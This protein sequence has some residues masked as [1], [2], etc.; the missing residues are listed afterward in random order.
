M[1]SLKRP[2][3]WFTLGPAT[4]GNVDA[5]IAAGATGVRYTLSYS[6]LDYHIEQAQRV[7]A[8]ARNR[9]VEV[10]AVADL[11]GNKFRLGAVPAHTYVQS[12]EKLTLFAGSLDGDPCR[13]GLP[14]RD[15][16]FFV[17]LEVGEVVVIGDGGIDLEIES[18]R[19][20]QCTVRVTN[21]GRIEPNRGLTVVGKVAR[22]AGLTDRDREFVK[23]ISLTDC[24]DVVAVSFVD[25]PIVLKEVRELLGDSEAAVLAKIETESGVNNALE[26]CRASDLIMAAR[27]DLALAI[28]WPRLYSAV[29]HIADCA[30]ETGTPWIL[31]TQLLEGF[32]EFG[33]PTRAEMCDLV[34]W[35]QAG[36]AGVMLSKET[37]FG[38]RA[39]E[40]IALSLELLRAPTN[41]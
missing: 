12:D 21:G 32:V 7:K 18:V 17:D 14:V 38:D 34:S 15:S 20:N 16:D 10:L 2:S 29:C 28:S 25:S 4:V 26:I 22:S 8:V 13:T 37:A 24:F 31:A 35:M 1:K 9:G 19:T 11:P 27:G 39:I 23:A 3:L 5:A 6:T 33:F 41:W 40:S 30:R 36:A